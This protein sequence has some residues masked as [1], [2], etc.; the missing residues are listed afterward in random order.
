MSKNIYRRIGEEFAKQCLSKR[1]ETEDIEKQFFHLWKICS[2]FDLFKIVV[3]EK[4]GGLE[5]DLDKMIDLMYGIGYG[6]GKVG[7]LFAANVHIWAC[8]V[9]ILKFGSEKII[10]NFIP[11][12]M[13][14][15]MIGAHAISENEAGSDVFNL[16]TSFSEVDGG[17]LLNGCKNYVTNSPFASVYLVYASRPNVKKTFSNTTCFLV[18]KDTVGFKEGELL[19]KMGMPLSPMAPIYLNNVYIEPSNILGSIN[20]GVNIFQYT[21]SLERT[22]LLAFQVG[23][24]EK[25]LETCVKFCRTRVQAGTSII[26]YQSVSDRLADMKVRLEASKLFMDSI[27]H[28]LLL[29]KNIFVDSSIAKLYISD[30]LY[31]N[32][33][34]AMKNYGTIGYLDEYNSAEQLKDSIGSYFYSGTSDIQKNIISSML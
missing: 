18:T 9:P 20:Q 11:D 34:D 3:P 8:M 29:K 1:N 10:R 25:Q 26:N 32:S 7:I 16:Q 28:K 17:Y 23:I 27:I 14:G 31:E 15:S 6:Y 4:Y 5:Y 30:S 33:I 21:M 12:L 13:S 24:M 22:F 2:E 19:K